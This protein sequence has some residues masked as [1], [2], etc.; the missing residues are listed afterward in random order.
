[1]SWRKGKRPSHKKWARV[2][3]KVLD[4]DGW[5]CTT[6]SKSGRL[7]VDHRVSMD[8][9]GDIYAMDNLQTLCRS[10]H[11]LKHSGTVRKKTSEVQ[12]WQR[13]LKAMW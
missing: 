5:K 10:C 9:G 12:D 2:R 11:I 3:L 4:R 8:D 7:E 6:C 1:M 13:Y